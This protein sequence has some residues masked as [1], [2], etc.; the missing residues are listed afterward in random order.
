MRVQLDEICSI[1]K[2]RQH[3]GLQPLSLQAPHVPSGQQQQLPLHLQ[4]GG[5][6]HQ[7]LSGSL[8]N[9]A[10][11]LPGSG[12]QSG[13]VGSGAAYTPGMG[14]QQAGLRRPDAQNAANQHAVAAAAQ[15]AAQAAL[16]KRSASLPAPLQ[17]LLLRNGQMGAPQGG[18]GLGQPLPGGFDIQDIDLSGAV[19]PCLAASC[20]LPLLDNKCVLQRYD[21]EAWLPLTL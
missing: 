19:T 7:G 9:P 5:T 16:L 14:N 2:L 15:A 10:A 12:Y 6:L 4:L 11:N 1:S 8:S 3:Q 13:A 20:F 21:G 17:G 18:P